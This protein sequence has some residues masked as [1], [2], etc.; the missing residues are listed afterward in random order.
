MNKNSM[1]K[2]D[3]D[4][5]IAINFSRRPEKFKAAE[6]YKYPSTVL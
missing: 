2:E 4:S 5:V 3:P 1:K 6:K